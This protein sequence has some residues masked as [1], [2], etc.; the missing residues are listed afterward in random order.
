MMP[1]DISK[2]FSNI[3]KMKTTILQ[4]MLQLA[5]AVF[6]TAQIRIVLDLSITPIHILCQLILKTSKIFTLIT[7]IL[8]LLKKLNRKWQKKALTSKT[9]LEWDVHWLDYPMS[10]H[11][12]VLLSLKRIQMI[13][14]FQHQHLLTRQQINLKLI[15]LLLNNLYLLCQF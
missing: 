6:I 15:M 14:R 7:Q 5:L 2:I 12:Y 4:I 10:S 3:H 13:N 11:Q 9:S 1:I 8:N